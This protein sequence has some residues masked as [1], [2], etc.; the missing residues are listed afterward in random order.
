MSSRIINCD[1]ICGISIGNKKFKI[2]QLADDTTL[3]LKNID[4]LKEALNILDEFHRISGLKLNKKKTEI[5]QLG[6]L[7]TTNYTLLGLR[8]EKEKV[9]A[10]GTWFYKDYKN[11]I[12]HTLVDELSKVTQVHEIWSTKN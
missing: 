4:S 12:T 7:C 10:L 11:S 5:L 1:N 8:W 6:I 2:S 3:F 9:H